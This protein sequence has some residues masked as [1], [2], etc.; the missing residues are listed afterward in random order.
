[1]VLCW[2]NIDLRVSMF[3]IS[4]INTSFHFMS[5]MPLTNFAVGKLTRPEQKYCCQ[6]G[7]AYY[8]YRFFLIMIK[9]KK[10]FEGLK[11]HLF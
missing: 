5:R 10:I 9:I 4:L 3:K 11:F 2:V 6:P 7:K 8:M 1:M